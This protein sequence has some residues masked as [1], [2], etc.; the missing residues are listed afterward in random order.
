MSSILLAPQW[1]KGIST[2]ASVH[3]TLSVPHHSVFSITPV[4]GGVGPKAFSE[5]GSSREDLRF[6]NTLVSLVIIA[7]IKS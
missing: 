5:G 3:H 7:K 1:L 6:D 4:V 2:N